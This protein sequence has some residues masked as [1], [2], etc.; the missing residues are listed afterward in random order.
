M[1]MKIDLSKNRLSA[2]CLMTN[3][4]IVKKR[5]RFFI[6][7]HNYKCIIHLGKEKIQSI[8]FS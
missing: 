6:F 2:C 4:W 5:Q 3:D 8:L 7:E 1:Q